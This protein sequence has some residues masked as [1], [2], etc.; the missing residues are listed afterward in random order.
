VCSV[1]LAFSSAAVTA[2]WRDEMLVGKG[3]G[4]CQGG[5]TYADEDVEEELA[6]LNRALRG[7]SLEWEEVDRVRE[8]H[9]AQDGV[10]H[11]LEQPSAGRVERHWRIHTIGIIRC[12]SILTQSTSVRETRGAEEPKRRGERASMLPPR[13]G[14]MVPAQEATPQTTPRAYCGSG[15]WYEG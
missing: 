7:G 11:A 3:L 10:D 8:L 12:I 13:K 15:H 2:T 6:I 1:V 14:R 5:C 9:I 4:G